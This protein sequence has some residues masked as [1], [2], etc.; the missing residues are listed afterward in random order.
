MRLT[1]GLY[2]RRPQAAGRISRFVHQRESVVVT[3][4]TRLS[5][6]VLAL[7]AAALTAPRPGEAA[8]YWPWCSQYADTD[9]A[10]T[11][12]AFISWEQCMQSVRGGMGGYCFANP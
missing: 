4:M 7:A 2:G 1:S 6:A 9:T 11:S 3:M 8:S 10:H 5:L 12:C